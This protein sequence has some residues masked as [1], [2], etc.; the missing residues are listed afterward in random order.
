[1]DIIHGPVFY[2]KH[3]M[4]SVCTSQE[5]H[6]VSAAIPIGKCAIS[7][8]DARILKYALTVLDIIHRLVFYL[9]QHLGTYVLPP[10]SG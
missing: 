5:A 9:E 7:V 2:L 8:C 4:Y 1:M 3:M 6:I 10:S